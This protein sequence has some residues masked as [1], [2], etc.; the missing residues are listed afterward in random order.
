MSKR[1]RSPP[2]SLHDFTA[3]TLSGDELLLSSLAGKVV[4]CTNVAS[5]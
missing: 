4:V 5:L 1:A 2:G 3:T